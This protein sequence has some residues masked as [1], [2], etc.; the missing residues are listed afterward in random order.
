MIRALR[1]PPL[2]QAPLCKTAQQR[3]VKLRNFLGLP[4]LILHFQFEVGVLCMADLAS[5]RMG[6]GARLAA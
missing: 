2:G 1:G 4:G 3:E 6:G 5:Q